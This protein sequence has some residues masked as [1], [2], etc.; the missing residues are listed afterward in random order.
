MRTGERGATG[1][2]A[3]MADVFGLFPRIVGA[4]G[5]ECVPGG[6]FAA[7]VPIFFGAADGVVV[8]AFGEGFGGEVVDATGA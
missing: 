4:F 6:F 2:L 7:V 1:A 8:G 5:L 3:E